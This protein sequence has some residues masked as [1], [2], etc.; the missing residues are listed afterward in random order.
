MSLTGSPDRYFYKDIGD[1]RKIVLEALR[2][3]AVTSLVVT[4]KT[5]EKVHA[6]VEYG[7]GDFRTEDHPDWKGPG[8]GG[9][10]DDPEYP[11]DNYDDDQLVHAS[12]GDYIEDEGGYLLSL[13]GDGVN[14]FIGYFDKVRNDDDEDTDPYDEQQN[15]I[16]Y[17]DNKD[18]NDFDDWFLPN[19]DQ[20]L[21]IYQRWKDGYL[22]GD[23]FKEEKYW[24]RD[25]SMAVDFATGEEVEYDEYDSL[26]FFYVRQ[27]LVDTPQAEIDY[28]TYVRRWGPRPIPPGEAVEIVT[29]NRDILVTDDVV[30]VKADK[31]ESLDVWLSIM[32]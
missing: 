18:Y 13:D 12:F 2:A 15:A 9:F 1:D 4:N 23:F 28:S 29:Y 31:P 6:T 20:L 30:T 3:C 27:T 32:E 7:E 16:A 17:V 26:N 21:I 25:Y 5:N 19:V 10:E 11:T 22:S 8:M 24:S 14:Y